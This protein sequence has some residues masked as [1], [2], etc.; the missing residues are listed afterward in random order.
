MAD[1]CR[2]SPERLASTSTSPTP[3]LASTSTQAVQR[4][5]GLPHP[6]GTTG[7]TAHGTRAGHALRRTRPSR[8]TSAPARLAVCA[9]APATQVTGAAAILGAIASALCVAP[10]LDAS[11]HTI[12]H[13]VSAA[14]AVHTVGI[15]VT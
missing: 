10:A 12:I 14:V 4:Q 6:L 2:T 13:T 11:V 3:R 5:R 15:A 1:S 9:V 8:P 7:E